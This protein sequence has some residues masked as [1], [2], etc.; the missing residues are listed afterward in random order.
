[1]RLGASTVG[2]PHFVTAPRCTQMDPLLPADLNPNRRCN[3][4]GGQRLKKSGV[5]R[6]GADGRIAKMNLRDARV[7]QTYRELRDVTGEFGR[8]QVNLG[9]SVGVRRIVPCLDCQVSRG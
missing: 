4:I 7:K 8:R 2:G 9:G 5:E 1:M 3:T 6:S